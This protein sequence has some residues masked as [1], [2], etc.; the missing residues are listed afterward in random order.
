MWTR[1]KKTHFYVVSPDTICVFLHFGG[2]GRNMT[3][4]G[5]RGPRGLLIVNLNFHLLL[6]LYSKIVT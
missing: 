5:S 4:H 6:L 3:I 2:Q 1:T